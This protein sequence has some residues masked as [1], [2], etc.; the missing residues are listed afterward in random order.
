[1]FMRLWT[2]LTCA[3]ILALSNARSVRYD[4]EDALDGRFDEIVDANDHVSRH[5]AQRRQILIQNDLDF[6]EIFVGPQFERKKV[7]Y[8]RAFVYAYDHKLRDK[9]PQSKASLTIRSANDVE[10]FTLDALSGSADAK[11]YFIKKSLKAGETAYGFRTNAHG[12]FLIGVKIA[13]FKKLDN[14][15]LTVRGSKRSDPAPVRLLMLSKI[16]KAFRGEHIFHERNG[17]EVLHEKH[18]KNYPSIQKAVYTVLEVAALSEIEALHQ[19]GTGKLE[20]GTDYGIATPDFMKTNHPALFD[21]QDREKPSNSEK[22]QER[23]HKRSEIFTEEQFDEDE[24][25]HR[26]KTFLNKDAKYD[27]VFELSLDENA[28]LLYKKHD[29]VHDAVK[30]FENSAPS[31]VTSL[32]KR[33]F[34]PLRGLQSLEKV[35]KFLVI[36]ENDSIIV[37]ALKGMGQVVEFII[38]KVSELIFLIVEV[39]EW[40]GIPIRTLFEWAA[41]CWDIDAFSNVLF[42]SNHMAGLARDGLSTAASH[43]TRNGINVFESTED[44]IIDSM[45]QI[46]ASIGG[47]NMKKLMDHKEKALEQQQNRIGAQSQYMSDFIATGLEHSRPENSMSCGIKQNGSTYDGAALLKS[48][49]ESISILHARHM[50]VSDLEQQVNLVHEK[51]LQGSFFLRLTSELIEKL[52]LLFVK[53]SR[54]ASAVAIQALQRIMVLVNGLMSASHCRFEISG[55]SDFIEKHLL[56]GKLQFNLMTLLLIPGS[57]LFL[58][59]YSS[60]YGGEPFTFEDTREL[61][62]ARS[63]FGLVSAWKSKRLSSTS[64]YNMLSWLQASQMTMFSLFLSFV[65]PIDDALHVPLLAPLLKVTNHLFSFPV[66]KQDR[67]PNKVAIDSWMLGVVPIFFSFSYTAID[68]NLETTTK[69]MHTCFAI[70]AILKQDDLDMRY[71]NGVSLFENTP[72]SI[73]TL[74]Q[75]SSTILK[76]IP[77]F[78]ALVITASQTQLLAI[79]LVIFSADTGRLTMNMY[80]NR[81]FR[82]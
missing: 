60:I 54:Y 25:S 42:I 36:H 33:D 43:Y 30:E 46:Q 71:K 70:A 51:N 26:Y 45:T 5:G 22:E 48:M 67:P 7:A 69:I 65:K 38:R 57:A 15:F 50:D 3:T 37:R 1:M 52:K 81:P 41:D 23:L 39:L 27:C 44:L 18:M 76:S 74:L 53:T 9:I 14:I 72:A 64:K 10:I 2:L 55:V 63:H 16:S 61:G 75:L 40:I 68:K 56:K 80:L 4:I 28:D 11:N 6:T 31:S 17:V 12:V 58:T 32:V 77:R 78:D 19:I 8:I 59:L 73:E 82:F 21:K 47:V 29:D 24:K 13:D 34:D 79:P 49:K 66:Q 35:S 62:D 20:S